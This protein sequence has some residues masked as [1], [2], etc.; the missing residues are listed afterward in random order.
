MPAYV[1]GLNRAVHDRQKLEEFRK[2][3][4]PT[5]EGLGAKRL[6]IYTPLT[7]LALIGPLEAAFVYE[8]P[9]VGTAKRWYESPA[10]QKARQL[11]R[12]GVA[13]IEL[14]IIDGG[15]IPLQNACR[16]LSSGSRKVL[17]TMT[18]ATSA[19]SAALD[20]VAMGIIVPMHVHGSRF[21]NSRL[22]FGLVLLLIA[23]VAAAILFQPPAWIV[24]PV[25]CALM[26][27]IFVAARRKTDYEALDP[28][29]RSHIPP[30]RKQPEDQ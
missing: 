12:N 15:Y 1:I 24:L 18:A 17:S 4:A 19:A 16:I 25:G 2:A 13:D 28:T 26:A 11:V 9:D 7:P 21:M 5:F 20:V 29:F 30:I 3:A 6:A 27:A 22:V 23:G 14:F 10:Y 8:F